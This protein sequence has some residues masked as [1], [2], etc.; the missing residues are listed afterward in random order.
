M[1]A[2][3]TIIGAGFVGSTAAHWIASKELGDVVLLDIAEGIP[4]GKGLDLAESAPISKSSAPTTTPT[5]PIPMSSW[6]PRV[7]RENPG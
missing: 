5:P 4:Q 6:S 2:K 1:R 7:L 3:I